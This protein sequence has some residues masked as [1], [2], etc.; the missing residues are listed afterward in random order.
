MERF[1]SNQFP[2]CLSLPGQNNKDSLGDFRRRVRISHLAQSG[3]VHK[4][5]VPVHQFDKRVFRAALGVG[6]QEREI[7]HT[8]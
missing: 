1:R 6:L 3:G 4:V 7:T 5:N 8:Y 2:D